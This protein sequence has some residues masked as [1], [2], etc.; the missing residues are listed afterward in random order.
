MAHKHKL[1]WMND[2]KSLRNKQSAINRNSF[3]F[4]SL[5]LRFLRKRHRAVEK[6]RK[7][8]LR[9][10][11]LQEVQLTPPSGI[12]RGILIV[13]PNLGMDPFCC[14]WL[15]DVDCVVFHSKPNRPRNGGAGQSMQGKTFEKEGGVGQKREAKSRASA[16]SFSR[17]GLVLP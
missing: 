12:I 1:G 2:W 17:A 7:P 11:H 5:W 13:Q 3:S 10:K 9:Q 4:V 8:L 16:R 14:S 15:A 6:Q